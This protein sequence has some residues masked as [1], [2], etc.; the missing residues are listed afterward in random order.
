MYRRVLVSELLYTDLSLILEISPIM[1]EIILHGHTTQI[2]I[3]LSRVIIEF[4]LRT[5]QNVAAMKS[6]LLKGKDY[7]SVYILACTLI[8]T[9]L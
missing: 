3:H 4:L 9:K 5:Y 7:S 1:L 6:R 2:H 8:C